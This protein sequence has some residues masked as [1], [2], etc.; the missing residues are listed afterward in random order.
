MVLNTRN[1]I[2][3]GDFDILYLCVV[4]RRSPILEESVEM[5]ELTNTFYINCKLKY[6]IS[7]QV[8]I[9]TSQAR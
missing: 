9:F 8:L 1:I 7:K 5:H 4:S 6:D 3:L 2:V